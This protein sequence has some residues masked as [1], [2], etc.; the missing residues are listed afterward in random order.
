MCTK[1][2]SRDTSDAITNAN[3]EI[4]FQIAHHK[5]GSLNSKESLPN[6]RETKLKK[7]DKFKPSKSNKHS[8]SNERLNLA[9]NKFVFYIFLL[10]IIVL[11]IICLYVCPYVLRSSLKIEV[12]LNELNKMKNDF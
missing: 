9:L 8:V 4:E 11:N 7:I 3:L 1:I 2:H 5:S 12:W 6:N 10:F